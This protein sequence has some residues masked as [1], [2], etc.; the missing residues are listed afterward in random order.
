[1]TIRSAPV[2]VQPD[3]EKARDGSRPFVCTDASGIRLGAVL[4]QEGE[5]KQL[6]PVYFASKGLSKPKR[7]IM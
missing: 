7:G 6:D 5:D 1:M 2:L 4:S 3:I